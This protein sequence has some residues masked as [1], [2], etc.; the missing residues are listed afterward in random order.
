MN[1]I[2]KIYKTKTMR[3][4]GIILS[5]MFTF[6]V[7]IGPVVIPSFKPE[8]K[9]QIL[10]LNGNNLKFDDYFIVK[11]FFHSIQENNGYLCLGTSETTS[12][13][14]GNYY[15]FLN[16]DKDLDNRF[17]AL[18]GA[19]RTCGM[20]IP[21]L[22]NHKEEL[23]GLN[24][25]YFVNPVYWREDLCRPSVEYWKRYCSY[26]LASRVEVSEENK[27][28][29][30]VV[31]ECMDVYNSIEK[32][33]MMSQDV[34]RNLRAKYAV[35]LAFLADTMNY[36]NGLSVVNSTK[37]DLSKL[38]GFGKMNLNEIDTV[39]NIEY[40]FKNKNWFKPINQSID[41][42]YREL[43]S[44]SRICK[45][46][47]INLTCIVGPYNNRFIQN[48]SAS[49]LGEYENTV[50]SIKELLSKENVAYIDAADISNVAGAFVDHQHHSSYG[51]YFIY[52]KIKDYL[53]EKMGN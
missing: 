12:I 17:S 8:S 31:E 51:A 20:Y 42:R 44:F 9:Q 47:K 14:G 23:A 45:N 13:K 16:N 38:K 52:L 46:L 6:L 19:G 53:N 27:E 29:Y 1:W 39:W 21:V 10:S 26:S 41:Y 37:D 24:I 35:D 33:M 2:D 30:K 22:L 43:T 25:I 18:S 7:I 5:F 50:K 40:A 11:D 36:Y 32:M 3:D 48:Y 28:N 34:I 15:N 4:Y 49:S